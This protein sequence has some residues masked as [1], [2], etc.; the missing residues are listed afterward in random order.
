MITRSYEPKVHLYGRGGEI[1]TPTP[2]WTP[3]LIFTLI[4]SRSWIY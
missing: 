4:I 2:H 3:K 1:R